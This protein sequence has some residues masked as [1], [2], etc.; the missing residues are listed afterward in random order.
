EV[1]LKQRTRIL[2]SIIESMGH[3]V[4]VVDDRGKFL[5]FNTA[6]RQILR[7]GPTGDPPRPLTPDDWTSFY[8]LYLPD[9]VPPYP[10]QRPPLMPAMRGE[11]VTAAEIFVRHEQTPPDGVWLMVDAC[12]LRD[13]AGA[14]RGG[15]AVFRDV[16]EQRRAEQALAASEMRFRDL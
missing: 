10:T 16:T 12:P 4:V 8:G 5:V 15:V 7:A 1:L 6:A 2:H 3:G 14:V 11:V 13:E 9:Q